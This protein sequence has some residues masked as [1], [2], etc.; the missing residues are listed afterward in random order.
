ML[1]TLMD[2]HLFHTIHAVK[3]YVR[4]QGNIH[5]YV[6]HAMCTEETCTCSK[7]MLSGVTPPVKQLTTVTP[8]YVT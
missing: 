6:K 5:G 2:L 4:R 1:S 7:G 3:P 8:I